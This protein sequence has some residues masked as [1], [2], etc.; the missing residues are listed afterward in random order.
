MKMFIVSLHQIIFKDGKLNGDLLN[1]KLH[2]V[3]EMY[4]LSVG[5]SKERASF[6]CFGC[7]WDYSITTNLEGVGVGLF[8]SRRFLVINKIES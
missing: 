5:K 3:D 1:F 6:G 2:S 8:E 4:K 7:K